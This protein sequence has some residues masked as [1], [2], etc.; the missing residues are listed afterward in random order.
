M[1]SMLS[2]ISIS[3]ISDCYR[4]PYLKVT[5][6]A[7]T[8]FRGFGILHFTGIKFCWASQLMVSMMVCLQYLT[9]TSI[10]F[11]AF[12]QIRRNIKH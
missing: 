10:T 4:R 9:F 12:V 3:E 2:T 6:I 5:I 1:P 8:F 7:G 11:C